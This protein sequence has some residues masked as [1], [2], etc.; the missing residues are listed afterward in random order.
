MGSFGGFYSGEKRKKKKAV[1]EK[2]ASQITR[3]WTPPKVQIIGKGKN[4][5]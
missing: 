4:K 1:L 5:V 2:Q 3:V